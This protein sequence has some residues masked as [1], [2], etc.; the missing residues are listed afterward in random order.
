MPTGE[1]EDVLRF[2]FPSHL[3]G[4]HAAMVRQFEWWFGGGA[5]AVIAERFSLLLERAT[6]GK[7]DHWAGEPRSRL[8]LIIILAQFSRSLYRG[9]ARV[10]AQDQRALNLALQGIEMVPATSCTR[11]PATGTVNL[12]LARLDSQ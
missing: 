5:D 7:L 3:S 9:T 11:T 10:F 6:R 1:F 4:E 8:A 2:W 12:T